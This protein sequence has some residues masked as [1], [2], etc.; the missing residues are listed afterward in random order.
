[1]LHLEPQSAGSQHAG[2]QR[3]GDLHEDGRQRDGR[4]HML[5]AVKAAVNGLFH[6]QQLLALLVRHC[7]AE[8]SPHHSYGEYGD[9]TRAQNGLLG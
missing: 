8:N 5:A 7:V 1:M 4:P 2:S 6:R 9:W 3:G